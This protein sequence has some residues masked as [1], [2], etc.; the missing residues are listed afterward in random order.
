[1]NPDQL[2]TYEAELV[3]QRAEIQQS[4][5][6]PEQR[7]TYVNYADAVDLVTATSDLNVEVTVGDQKCRKMRAI[8]H[9][10]N[11]INTGEYG[12]CM[13]CEEE[14]PHNRLKAVPWAERC[15]PCEAQTAG[16]V[17]CN[18]GTKKNGKT[19]S[20]PMLAI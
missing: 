6:R 7:P 16:S 11:R 1:M 15:A 12:I 14:I 2:R 9:A 5:T 18:G 17:V 19:T 4:A 3:K 13:R 10:L 20:R 8:E